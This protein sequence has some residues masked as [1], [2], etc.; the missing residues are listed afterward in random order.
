M[1]P[2]SM[3]STEALADIIGHDVEIVHAPKRPG[4]IYVTYFDCTKAKEKLGW[5]A[6]TN[7]AD[8]LQLTVDFFK[9]SI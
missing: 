5:V 8:G 3:P 7:L 9:K 2:L 1:V 6:K 4:D